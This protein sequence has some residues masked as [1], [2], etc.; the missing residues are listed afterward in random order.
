MVTEP[1]KVRQSEDFLRR[2]W[3]MLDVTY[4]DIMRLSNGLFSGPHQHLVT[5]PWAHYI[6]D[7]N[8]GWHLKTSSKWS[9]SFSHSDLDIR[10]NMTSS[11][12]WNHQELLEEFAPQTVTLRGPNELF[13][14]VIERTVL[15]HAS[16]YPQMW[17][18]QHLSDWVLILSQK[19]IGSVFWSTFREESLSIE[20]T[21]LVVYTA[22]HSKT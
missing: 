15:R 8:Y 4:S 19:F 9:A 3:I 5:S 10:G 16:T 7:H 13:I 12:H 6:L 11:R 21:A 2:S 18:S 22:C 20:S 17:T 14:H 1:P